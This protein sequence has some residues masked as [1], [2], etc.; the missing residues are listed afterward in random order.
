MILLKST[1]KSSSFEIDIQ[2][3]AVVGKESFVYSCG[4]ISSGTPDVTGKAA[5]AGDVGEPY[6]TTAD[7]CGWFAANGTHSW[8]LSTSPFFFKESLGNVLGNLN[9]D[10]RP[11]NI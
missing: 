9:L 2:Y 6:R 4:H 11:L 8:H 10:G 1:N 7:V 5:T 3:A